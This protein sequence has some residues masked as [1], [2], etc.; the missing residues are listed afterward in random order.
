[1][2][3]SFGCKALIHRGKTLVNDG[4]LGERANEGIYIGVE[5][6]ELGKCFLVY[7]GGRIFRG[8]GVD[9]DPEYFPYRDDPAYKSKTPAEN[10]DPLQKA[11]T[12]KPSESRLKQ[13][14]EA[15]RPKNAFNKPA[16]G[17]DNPSPVKR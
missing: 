9:F 13:Q 17:I 16:Q 1:M 12:E 3:K 4:F 5:E 7:S 8:T 10:R 15:E 6:Y 2:L 11:P 14:V